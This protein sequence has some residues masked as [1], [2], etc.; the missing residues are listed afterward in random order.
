MSIQI[1]RRRK[2]EDL[3]RSLPRQEAQ[4][5]NTWLRIDARE[6]PPRRTSSVLAGI[7]PL[8]DNKTTSAH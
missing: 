2:T 5:G 3:Q 1:A 6:A 7:S 4:A 8:A